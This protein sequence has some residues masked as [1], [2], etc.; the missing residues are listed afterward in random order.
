MKMNPYLGFNGNCEAAFDFYAQ[1]LGGKITEMHHYGNS[2]MAE[3]VPAEVHDKVM[4]A[5]LT[6]ADGQVLMGS[7][8]AGQCPFQAIQGI[9]LSL[10]TNDVA[11]AEKIF[12]VL[13]TNGNVTMALE[14]T[15]WAER[16]G[17]VTDQFGTPWMV[18]C[19]LPPA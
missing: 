11:E 13:S 1:H 18:N 15:F 19:D 6:L 8:A 10:A 14:K 4:H 12:A 7:D 3:Q 2:P 5:Q 17:M 9:T 16:F